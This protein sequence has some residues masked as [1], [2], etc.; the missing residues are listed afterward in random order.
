MKIFD[1]QMGLSVKWHDLE[2]FYN[3]KLDSDSRDLIPCNIWGSYEEN[4][5]NTKM[6]WY[7]LYQR[8]VMIINYTKHWA[9]GLYTNVWY[10]NRVKSRVW[11]CSKASPINIHFYT[12]SKNRSYHIITWSVGPSI[13]PS[14]RRVRFPCICKQTIDR[15]ELKLWVN[16]LW[17]SPDMIM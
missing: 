5:L 9:T 8:S 15:T 2:A 12:S 4:I 17:N 10:L 13:H 16:L 14:I 11:M 3:A 7:F 1:F 6:D